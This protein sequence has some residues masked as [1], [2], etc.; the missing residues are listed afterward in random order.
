GPRV[1]FTGDVEADILTAMFYANVQD[2]RHKIDLTGMYHTSTAYA[3]SWGDYTGFGTWADR[4]GRY[5][6][7][8]WTR[9][10][11]RSLQELTELGYLDPATSCADYCFR[12]ARRWAQD[13]KL[14]YRG[15]QLPPHWSRIA[16]RPEPMVGHGVF[17]N[18]GHGLVMLFTYKLWQRQPDPAGWLR[19]HW[20]DVVAAGDWIAWQLDHPDVSGATQVLQTDSECAGGIGPAKYADMACLEGLDAYA[21]M[22]D[23][24]GASEAAERW[25][26]TAAR[27]RAGMEAAYFATDAY[28]P[29][30]TLRPAGWP[31]L[32]TNLG[33]LILRADLQGW[34]SEDEAA[35][36]RLRDLHAYQRL[37]DTYRP[38]G[39]YGSAMG[40]GQGFVTEA[41]L[42]LDRMQD[43]SAMLHWLAK[44]TW[45]PRDQPFIVP[46]G[47][48]I[49]P[50]GRFWHRVGDLGNGVQEGE[51]VKVMRLVLGVDDTRPER[52][53]LMPRLPSP[54][55]ELNLSNYPV[56][57]VDRGRPVTRHVTVR[58][59]RAGDQASIDLASDGAIAH[60]DT[61]LGPFSHAV[62]QAR[63]N[64]QV[65]AGRPEQSG[66]SWWL[67]LPTQAEVNR[68]HVQVKEAPARGGSMACGPFP[69]ARHRSILRR[70]RTP[71]AAGHRVVSGAQGGRTA[72]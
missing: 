43:A 11:G 30:W 56:L 51:A 10:L 3:P 20:S 53:R 40:Y 17:E 59:H 46:E 31:H 22:A 32:S 1:R 54:W 50:G 19:L 8:S 63:L 57:T 15:V 4:V 39:F 5:Y 52:T 58:Y 71:G 65:V 29:T 60:L 68:M 26:Q 42:L 6:D 69:N 67:W 62:D 37:V 9:D 2:I 49:E 14:A 28:G 61:R 7:E 35:D 25:R 72:R 45:Y 47:C 23:S 34:S 70:S 13:P 38:F 21:A 36:W 33:P 24:I 41:A 16:N 55:T 64:G 27:L 18:D 48:E 12:A 44:A 66:D